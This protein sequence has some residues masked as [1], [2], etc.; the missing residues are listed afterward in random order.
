MKWFHV[1]VSVLE[2]LELCLC[3]VWCQPEQTF[4]RKWRPLRLSCNVSWIWLT[5][6]VPPFQNENWCYKKG[7]CLIE[8]MQFIRDTTYNKVRALSWETGSW[9][10]ERDICCRVCQRQ[11]FGRF[12]HHK[13]SAILFYYLVRHLIKQLR[14]INSSTDNNHNNL[15]CLFK[16]LHCFCWLLRLC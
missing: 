1:Y 8:R 13:P 15:M 2:V 9:F 14:W 11:R 16:L 10:P 7:C 6:M 4:C 3:Q 5:R 12:E